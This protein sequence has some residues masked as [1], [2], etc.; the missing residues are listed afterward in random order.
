MG[1]VSDLEDMETFYPARPHGAS[2]F[3]DLAL[4]NYYPVDAPGRTGIISL[5]R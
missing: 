4:L 3:Y 1:R 2:R 5:H